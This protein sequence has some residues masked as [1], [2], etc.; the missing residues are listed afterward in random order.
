MCEKKNVK[1]RNLWT[2]LENCRK[3]RLG[4]FTK[5]VKNEK[6]KKPGDSLQKSR[7]KRKNVKN[8]GLFTKFD[9]KI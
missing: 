1:K 4:L 7:R 5:L 9:K 2:Y 8:W 3:K 6:M